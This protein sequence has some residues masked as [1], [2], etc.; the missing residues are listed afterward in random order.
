[1]SQPSFRSAVGLVK[2]GV[3]FHVA[4]G[5]LPNEFFELDTIEQNAYQI[6]YGQLEGYTFNWNTFKFME[7]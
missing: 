4:F 1:V 3:P 2:S 7:P 5:V 6:I